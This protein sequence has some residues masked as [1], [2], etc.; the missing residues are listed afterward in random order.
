[1]LNV[2]GIVNYKSLLGV[3]LS[4]FQMTYF[5]SGLPRD[6]LIG[7]RLDLV[8]DGCWMSINLFTVKHIVVTTFFPSL[9]WFR[10]G[11]AVNADNIAV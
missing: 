3:L 8:R 9:C 1:M 7:N 2:P 11:S 5:I 4:Q 10:A 6:N